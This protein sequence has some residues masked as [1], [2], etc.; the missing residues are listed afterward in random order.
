[1]YFKSA[2]FISRK[3]EYQNNYYCDRYANNSKP[4]LSFFI[5][6]NTSS[7]SS[8]PQR[9]GIALAEDPHQHHNRRNAQDKFRNRLGVGQAVQREDGI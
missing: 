3:Q 2:K 6:T 1:M 8:F 4:F 5:H 9:C 7:N